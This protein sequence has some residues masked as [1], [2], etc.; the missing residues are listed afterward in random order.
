[1]RAHELFQ[2]VEIGIVKLSPF[3]ADDK[4]IRALRRVVHLRRH[5]D[6]VAVFLAQFRPRDGIKSIYGR[7]GGNPVS[8][9]TKNGQTIV[10]I[11]LAV[12]VARRDEPEE[13]EWISILGF[14]RVG[15][16]LGRHGKGDL[17]AAMG[18]LYRRRFTGRDGQERESWS[19]LAD[20]V[21]SA[22]TVRPS[23]GRERTDR[24]SDCTTG[25]FA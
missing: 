16:E 25:T 18:R 12:N 11:S 17:L 13:T 24:H 5:A 4:T 6:L 14:R 19:L 21:M 1:M 15:D 2:P 3:R 20:A 23:G 8:R 10:T 7:A 22:R 9:E